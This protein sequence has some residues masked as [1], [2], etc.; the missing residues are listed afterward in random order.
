MSIEQW[1]SL[2]I[3]FEK[4]CDAI[5]NWKRHQLRSVHQDLART[6]VL[7]HLDDSSVFIFMDWAMKWLETRYREKQSDWFAKKGIPW[8]VMV[9]IR[10]QKNIEN[11]SGQQVLGE[12]RFEHRTFAH[13]FDYC[14]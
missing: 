10:R 2:K 14:K 11:L 5:L 6:H 12:S 4:S 9:V 13:V 1:S 8:H 7:D 3:N